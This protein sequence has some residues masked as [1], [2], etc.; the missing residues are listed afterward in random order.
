MKKGISAILA[1]HNEERVIRSCLESIK[2][3]VD[4]ILIVHDGPCEDKTLDIC[5]E[6]TKHIFVQPRKKMIALHLAL[7]LRKV[8][9]EWVLKI[10]ADERLSSQLQKNIRKLIENPEVDA[11]SFLWPFWDGKKE[12]TKRWPKKMALYRLSKISFLGFPHWDDPKINGKIARV[13]LKLEHK[14]TG[15]NSPNWKSSV[16]K[17]LKVYLLEQARYTL[18]DFK[19]FDQFQYNKTDFPI[20]I[21][22]RRKFPLL[23]AIPFS[24]LAFFKTFF[25]E[26]AWKEGIIAVKESFYILI[27]YLVL[28]F[29]I[30]KL[31]KEKP[32]G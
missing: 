13:N 9:Y 11:Y 18:K 12:T 24:I 5:N 4:E 30:Y 14:T 31:K 25:T 16:E 20:Q 21:R 7:L 22:I 1:V 2:D 6:Y 15:G 8:T 26:E 27:Y 3:V 19:E 32:T 17:G 23:S 28:G 10:D 29:R